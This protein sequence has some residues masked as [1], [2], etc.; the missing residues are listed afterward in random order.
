M[1][2][3]VKQIEQVLRTSLNQEDINLL[4]NQVISKIEENASFKTEYFYFLTLNEKQVLYAINQFWRGI[5]TGYKYPSIINTSAYGCLANR[6]CQEKWLL[7]FDQ[8][9]DENFFGMVAEVAK[10]R[11]AANIRHFINFITLSSEKKRFMAIC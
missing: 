5:L 7:I 3:F 11:A 6:A 2:T 9:I 8:V 1:T 10:M 4:A